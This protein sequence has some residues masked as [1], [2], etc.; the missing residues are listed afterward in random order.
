VVDGVQ[1]YADPT[2]GPFVKEG[3][4][5][6][7]TGIRLLKVYLGLEGQYDLSFIKKYSGGEEVCEIPL[8]I[9]WQPKGNRKGVSVESSM[10]SGSNWQAVRAVTGMRADKHS[11]VKLIMNDNRMGEFD[12]MF[13]FA[14][15][16]ELYCNLC[17][18]DLDGSSI[19]FNI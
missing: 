3:K 17:L 5:I 13:D 15:V 6:C 7:E 18:P 8:N 12:D 10:V 16:R 9:A 1:M 19:V 14:R 11:I 2:R 4:L